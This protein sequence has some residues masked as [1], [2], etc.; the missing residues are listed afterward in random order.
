MYIDYLKVTDYITFNDKL[1]TD[2]LADDDEWRKLTFSVDYKEPDISIR[3]IGAQLKQ[4]TNLRYWVK[5]RDVWG[6][7]ERGQILMSDKRNITINFDENGD[8]RFSENKEY[9]NEAID[10]VIKILNQI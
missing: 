7:L 3:T 5:S 9:Y 6:E 4:A 10:G 2:E 8:V 1:N